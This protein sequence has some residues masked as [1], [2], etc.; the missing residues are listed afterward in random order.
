MHALAVI[1]IAGFLASS[2]GGEA[3]PAA[4]AFDSARRAV[5]HSAA[6][7][8]GGRHADADA[9]PGGLVLLLGEIDR[10][11]ARLLLTQFTDVYLGEAQ[12][13]ALSYAVARQGRRMEKH[14]LEIQ[15]TGGKCRVLRDAQI[16]D[17]RRRQMCLSPTARLSRI[18]SLLALIRSGRLPSYVP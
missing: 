17:A 7:V 6:K 8:L 15:R 1:V 4:F 18:S 11:E 5:I 10:E 9:D 13:G 14:L 3:G 16:D 12:E 2:A